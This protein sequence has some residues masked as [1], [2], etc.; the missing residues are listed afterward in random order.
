MRGP[1]RFAM[2]S[3]QFDDAPSMLRTG[4][5]LSVGHERP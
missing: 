4:K 3:Q 1:G 2:A 5:P